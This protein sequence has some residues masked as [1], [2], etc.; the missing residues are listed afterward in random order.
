L[1]PTILEFLPAGVGNF[2][3]PFAGS[4][5]VSLAVAKSGL[6]RRLVIAD[7]LRPLMAIWT[8]VLTDPRGLSDDYEVIWRGSEGPADGHFLRVREEYNR[9]PEPAKLLYLLAR[10]VK[11]AVRFNRNGEFNQ[12]AD[13]RR[14]GMSPDKMRS[15]I[16]GAHHVLV[17]RTDAIAGDY[18]DILDS[19]SPSDFVYMDPPYQGTSG[20]RDR[21]YVA[22]LDLDRF[23]DQLDRLNT[24]GVRYAVS[25]DG[26]CGEKEY[27]AELPTELRLQRIEIVVGRSSQAT[28]NGRVEVTVESLYLSPGI[29]AVAQRRVSLRGSQMD[30]LGVGSGT[31]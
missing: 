7:A 28:L 22:Q 6:A 18:V 16:L 13:L 17:G 2:F 27:G 25:F 1:A 21:R 8:R 15:N 5:A 12:S 24:R 20:G 14:R 4:A 26:R 11:N 10:C 31:S 3:E 30:L 9:S 19:A 23:V 29:P